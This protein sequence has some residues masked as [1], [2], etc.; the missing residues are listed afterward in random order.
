MGT[1]S[2]P[3]LKRQGLGV[4]HPPFSS[5]EDKESVEYIK[6]NIIN[7]SMVMLLSTTFSLLIS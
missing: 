6:Y 4:D 5:A 7:L 1:G 3:G 2:L